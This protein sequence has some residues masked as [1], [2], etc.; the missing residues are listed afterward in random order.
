MRF[1]DVAGW[2]CDRTTIPKF[3]S[4]D[5]EFYSDLAKGVAA[6]QVQNQGPPPDLIDLLAALKA[7]IARPVPGS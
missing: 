2:I 4:S 3:P 6:W 7:R 1:K 5:V